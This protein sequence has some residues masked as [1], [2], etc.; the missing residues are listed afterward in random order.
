MTGTVK[1]VETSFES[2]RVGIDFQLDAALGGA[3]ISKTFTF[4]T[5]EMFTLAAVQAKALDYAKQ[6]RTMYT[7]VDAVRSLID[8]PITIPG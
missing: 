4:A 1:F 8:K 2:V 3:V 6:L 5:G 7:N